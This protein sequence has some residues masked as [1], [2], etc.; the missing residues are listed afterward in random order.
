MALTGIPISRAE[1]LGRVAERCRPFSDIVS[2]HNK[3]R[4]PSRL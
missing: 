2:L 4:I 3:P 1:F